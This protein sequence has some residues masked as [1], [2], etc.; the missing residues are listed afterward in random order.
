MSNRLPPRWV[1]PAAEQQFG[2]FTAAQAHAAGA[3][4]SQV[5][6]RRRAGLWTTVAGDGLA[7][8]ATP[9]DTWLRAQAAALTWP[10]AVV[11]LGS[12]AVLH[13]FPVTAPDA[14]HVQVPNRRQGR[15]GLLTHEM[16]LSAS[17]T[18]GIGL[19]RVT[20]AR[21]TLFDCLGRLPTA[22][23]EDLLAW[24]ASRD[25]VDALA[26][27]DDLGM[28]PFWWGNT[29]RRQALED[30]L[31]GAFNPAERRLHAILTEAG[32]D[33]W[34]GNQQVQVD[35][36][37]V[38]RADVLFHDDRLV[39]EVDGFASHGPEAFQHDRTRQNRLVAAG[40]TV[41]RFTWLDLTERPAEVAAEVR[42]T[43]ERLRARQP[44]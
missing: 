8:A 31:Q 20:S 15:A 35:G 41:L 40:Y 18:V 6:R 14:V 1:P 30:L 23:S 36:V 2:L 19:A 24:A 25:R 37:V 9:V 3:S 32:I 16:R 4:E 39:V 27:S 43:L 28:R 12:A 11:C 5:R 26:L 44:V 17:E 22:A 42:A 7:D 38:A 33:G 34:L 21:R 29:R 13:G 10:D